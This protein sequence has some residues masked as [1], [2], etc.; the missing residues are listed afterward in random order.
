[1]GCN[2]SYLVRDLV[3]GLPLARDGRSCSS[4]WPCLQGSSLVRDRVFKVYRSLYSLGHGVDTIVL[5]HAEP[6]KKNEGL[7]VFSTLSHGYYI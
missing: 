2:I 7:R 5:S 4:S 6:W 1:M 3:R